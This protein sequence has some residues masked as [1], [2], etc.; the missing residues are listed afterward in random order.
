MK[1]FSLTVLSFLFSFASYA[2][3][4]ITGI[5]AVCVDN[6][7]TLSNSTTGGTWS[8]SLPAI[9][10]IG[11][12]SGIVTGATAGVTTITYAV[13]VSYVTTTVTVNPLPAPI[14]GTPY[15]CV[16]GTTLLF[17]ATLG[18]SMTSSNPAVATV[19]V[20]TDVVIGLTPGT[21][22]ITYTFMTGCSTFII[23]KVNPMPAPRDGSTNLCLGDT[24][25]MIDIAS[26]GT[27]SS[28]NIAVAT[29][30]S[31]GLL[32][33]IS[34]G[35]TIIS[36]S[37]PSG[38]P[39]SDTIT[40]VPAPATITGDSNVCMGFVTTLADSSSGGVWSSSSPSIATIGSITGI[41][42]GLTAGTD[43]IR[44]T[45]AGT[46][47]SSIKVITVDPSPCTSTG[48]NEF[49]VDRGKVNLYPNPSQELLTIVDAADC[50]M[51]IF[52]LLGQLMLNVKLISVKESLKI[53]RLAS[54]T[55]IIQII[56]DNK[57]RSIFRLVKE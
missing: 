5:T 45:L 40:V 1:W 41:V 49:P 22:T 21:V 29:I 10:T 31:T 26:G 53:D 42:S 9:A 17:D 2:L 43:S 6:T 39:G 38:C 16:G 28:S 34:T 24:T 11:S 56:S 30:T 35:T 50:E 54:G 52:N 37:Q 3:T 48:L 46:G 51:K 23:F 27:W 32:S 44:Y 7:I 47:C 33:G 15:V 36:Y 8:S 55:Y 18:G 57:E 25:T 20:S 14:T 12:A 19:G 4:P 13:G